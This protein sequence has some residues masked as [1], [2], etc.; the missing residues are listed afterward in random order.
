MERMPEPHPADVL[1]P[2]SAKATFTLQIVGAAACF[3]TALPAPFGGLPPGPLSTVALVLLAV[4]LLASGYGLT[5]RP[6]DWRAWGLAAAAALFA[7][8]GFP[9][10]WDSAAMVC[11]VATALLALGTLLAWAIPAVRYAVITALMVFHF[12][13]LVCATTSPDPEP[14]LTLQMS[15]RVYVP[16]YRFFYLSN[17]YHFYSPEPGPA[18]LLFILVTTESDVVDPKTGQPKRE[19]SW[20]GLPNRATQFIDPLGMTYQRRLSIT[21][22]VAQ[23]QSSGLTP[24]NFEKN[25]AANR[26]QQVA[27]NVEDGNARIPLLRQ[28]DQPVAQ[29]RVPTA[30][31]SRYLL[32]SY[33]RHIAAEYS[34]PGRRV[35]SVKIVRAEHRVMQPQLFLPQRDPDT[36]RKRDEG[37]K[38]DTPFNP[39]TYRPY[40]LGEYGPTGE[41]LNPTD[42]MLYWLL[43]IVPRD[44][45]DKQGRFF[46]DYMSIYLKH[47]FPWTGGVGGAP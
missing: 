12:G 18:S 44:T 27:V 16:Y 3:L 19:S 28:I 14:W 9:P 35:V 42:P 29:Y 26:R 31:V 37:D 1:P 7:N 5:L 41:L 2:V 25:D 22:L 45:P 43:P 39:T 33:A 8:F 30:Q 38:G 20:L 40:Y 6:G 17:A 34:A 10:H 32:P 36:G 46:E 24:D 21:E 4:G 47:E 23:T 15:Q 13:A 11:R